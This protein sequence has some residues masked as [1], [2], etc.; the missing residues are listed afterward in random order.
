MPRL[1]FFS[2]KMIPIKSY[3]VFFHLL[4]QY[5]FVFFGKKNRPVYSFTI[6]RQPIGF[7]SNPRASTPTPELS[8]RHLDGRPQ[9]IPESRVRLKLE[10]PIRPFP[11][12]NS[13]VHKISR[14][15]RVTWN[16]ESARNHRLTAHPET[17]P[18][19]RS[20]K[21]F[22]AS[23]TVQLKHVKDFENTQ[24]TTRMQSQENKRRKEILQNDNQHK[25]RQKREKY[26]NKRQN[27]ENHQNKNQSRAKHQN[28]NQ[29]KSPQNK[30]QKKQPKNNKKNSSEE[31]LQ[32]SEEIQIE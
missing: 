2:I 19:T 16:N 27:K 7:H 13:K 29:K 11:P 24:E 3:L 32:T 30:N 8:S 26:Q 10:L 21:H 23:K 17:T 14:P 12:Q 5:G 20:Q 22:E 28:K 25:T 6:A 1:G 9:G 31:E 4:L 18:T 15:Y